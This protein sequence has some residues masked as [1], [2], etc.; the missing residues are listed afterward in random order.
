MLMA[1][2]LPFMAAPA[3]PVD[4]KAEADARLDAV[5]R[6]WAKA[7]DAVHESHFTIRVS[8]RDRKYVAVIPDGCAGEP[9]GSMIP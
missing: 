2:R 7:S 4:E 9:L 6:E 1:L 3:A 5:L 8:E